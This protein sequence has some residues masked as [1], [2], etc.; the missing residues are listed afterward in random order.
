MVVMVL[1]VLLVLLVM[2]LLASEVRA[3]MAGVSTCRRACAVPAA[4]DVRG[5]ETDHLLPKSLTN[6]VCPTTAG[7]CAAVPLQCNCP[8]L[9]H[10]C[11]FCGAAHCE[12]L[13]SAG[14]SQIYQA[15][16]SSASAAATHINQILTMPELPVCGEAP[17]V[18]SGRVAAA[19]GVTKLVK[20]A[21]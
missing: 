20:A 15:T 21:T 3:A 1:L 11:S 2:V 12:G 10:A 19:A 13:P 6:K 17:M 14:P 4:H 8:L 5:S 7:S 9:H 16:G 18:N